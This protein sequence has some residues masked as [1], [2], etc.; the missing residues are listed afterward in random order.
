MSKNDFTAEEFADRQH[1]VRAKMEEKGIDLLLVFHPTNIQYL[2][3]S[4]AKSYQE[5]QVLF[6]PLED[7]P[8]TIMMRLAEVPEMTDH[9][10]AEDVRGWGGRE[11]EDPVEVFATIMKEKGYLNRRIGLEV[12]DFYMHPY[13]YNRIKDLLGDALCL[14]ASFLVHDLKL[15][16]SPAELAYIRRA[17]DLA[18]A[19]MRSAVDIIADG[20]SEMEVAGAVYQTI[21]AGGSDLPAS[22]MNFVSGE[23][24]CYGHG[25]PSPR[26]IRP[27]DFMHLEYGASVNRYTT[28]I[29]RH[30][31]LGEP[32]ARMRELH[33]IV[34]DA[35][36]ACIG[37]IRA[38]V[39]GVTPHLAAKKVIADH[40]L[41]EY[42][43]HT[44]GY[45]IA[46]G[47]PPS[48]GEYIHLFADSTYTLEAGMILSVEPPIFIHEEKL[49][50]RI[51][52]NVLVTETGC[53]ILSG[54]TRDLTIIEP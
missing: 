5:F 42:R 9:C 49:G 18:D 34:L 40:G 29:A 23:R 4:R 54:F 53:E 7:A 12:P 33:Q 16:K 47:Y 8:M 35:C 13:N 52:D 25:A 32:T 44:T 3:G 28:T 22:P 27:G 39:S 24:T 10:L 6:F 38:G 45:G 50:A 19:G 36:D 2:S 43:V 48:W 30:L 41:D 21:L 17:S 26:Q 11:P 37:E 51:I 20:V 15:V 14:D 46:P 31:C 1:R